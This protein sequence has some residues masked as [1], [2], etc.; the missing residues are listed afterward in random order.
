MLAR[1]TF[2]LLASTF[3]CLLLR[4]PAEEAEERWCD[5][6]EV[7]DSFEV[8]RERSSMAEDEGSYQWLRYRHIEA[9]HYGSSE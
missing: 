8:V 7:A 3:A 1:S 5:R 2:S 9:N 6:C 4:L